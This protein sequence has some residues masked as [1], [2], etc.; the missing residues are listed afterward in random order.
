MLC[1]VSSLGFTP[2]LC[3]L[4]ISVVDLVL[5]RLR[6]S[7]S[8]FFVFIFRLTFWDSAKA[9]NENC[10]AGISVVTIGHGKKEHPKPNPLLIFPAYRTESAHQSSFQN[11]S[12]VP[13]L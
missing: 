10:V 4:L 12:K 3:F 1:C 2:K 6:L 8:M 5:S 11:V 7:F 13:Q 9:K